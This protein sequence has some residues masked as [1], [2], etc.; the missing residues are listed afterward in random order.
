MQKL[1][2]VV[3][4]YVVALSSL[5]CG[6]SAVGDVQKISARPGVRS[7]TQAT[8]VDRTLCLVTLG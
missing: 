1:K 3:E 7:V 2:V 4:R 6:F 8:N 5:G